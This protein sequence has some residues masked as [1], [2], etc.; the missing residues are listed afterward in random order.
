MT[1][2]FLLIID[3]QKAAD[4]SALASSWEHLLANHEGFPSL[5]REPLIVVGAR[6]SLSVDSLSQNIIADR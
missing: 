5:V 6:F 4:V 1:G 3:L 2:C